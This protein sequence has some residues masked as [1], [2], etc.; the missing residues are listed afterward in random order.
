[1]LEQFIYINHKGEQLDFGKGGLF[2]NMNDLRDFKWTVIQKNNKV[3]A[4]SMGVVTKSIP[5]V[6]KADT[7]AEGIALKN[8]LFEI[9]EKDVLGVKHGKIV[10]GDYYLKC[11]ITASKK[12]SY[13][14]RTRGNFT[15]TITTDYPRWV[16]EKQY[17][18]K[19][20]MEGISDTTGGDYEFDFPMDYARE[21]PTKRIVN[22]G[23]E[24]VNF[25]LTV[26]GA[27]ENPTITIGGHVYRVYTTLVSGEYMK[28]NSITKKVYKVKSNGEQVSLFHYRDRDNEIHEKIQPGVNDVSWDGTFGFDIIILEERSEPKWT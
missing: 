27:C 5:I 23:I 15:I 28:I 9:C 22:D 24:A 10:V 14:D 4:F 25:E 17:I 18:I 2:A 19:P 11:F 16:K 13:L 12:K 20:Y 7:E 8:R 6:V 1:M 3:S 21:L 26:Y